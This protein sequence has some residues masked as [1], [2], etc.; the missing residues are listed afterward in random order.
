MHLAR[1]KAVDEIPVAP[2]RPDPKHADSEPSDEEW[3]SQR[4]RVLRRPDGEPERYAGQRKVVPLVA[5]E[6]AEMGRRVV[7]SS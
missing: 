2:E 3:Q 6:L 7:H 4:R 1:R 5:T